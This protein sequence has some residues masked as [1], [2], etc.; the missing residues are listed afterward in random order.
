[1]RYIFNDVAALRVIKF[2]SEE[3][4]IQGDTPSHVWHMCKAWEIAANQA[5]IDPEFI[6]M[7]GYLVKPSCNGDYRI[8]PVMINWQEI[9]SHY[10]E[11]PRQ[12]GMLFYP[13]TIGL[14][15]PLDVFQR[16]EEIHPFR[17]GNGRVGQ[18][19]YNWFNHTMENP[20]RA[21]FKKR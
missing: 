20:V 19:I 3:V 1:M 12:M 16:F 21:E 11:I 8:G 15:T 7:L 4:E 13:G 17:D 18:I 14:M 9:G 6:K 5:S 2:C 10:L